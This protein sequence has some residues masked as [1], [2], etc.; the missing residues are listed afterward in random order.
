MRGGEVAA[1][2][3]NPL[4]A[5]EDAIRRQSRF[6]GERLDRRLQ[7]TGFL[8]HA[9]SLKHKRAHHGGKEDTEK[10][11]SVSSVSSVVASLVRKRIQPERRTSRGRK[12]CGCRRVPTRRRR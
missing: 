11:C 4:H 9:R 2:K 12:R 10:R 6:D 5:G 1:L 7:K 8:F 3:R